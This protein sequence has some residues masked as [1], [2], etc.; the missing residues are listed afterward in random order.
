MGENI[1]QKSWKFIRDLNADSDEK[2]SAVAMTDGRRKYT[3]RQLFRQW[4]KYAEVF[5]ALDITRESCSVVGMLSTPSV[6][7]VVAFYSLNMTG[8]CVS[9][10]HPND[11]SNDGKLRQS[12]ILEGITDLVLCSSLL[13][14]QLLERLVITKALCN[15]RNIIILHTSL[16]GKYVSWNQQYLDNMNYAQLKYCKDVLFM[17]D[18]LIRYEATPIKYS[19]DPDDTALIVHTSGTTK[20]IHKPIPFTDRALNEAAGM[21]RG[22]ERFKCFM[23]RA[24]TCLGMD[25]STAYSAVDMMHVPLS[26]GAKV[27]AVPIGLLNPFA[28]VA[29]KD[30]GINVLFAAGRLIDIWMQNGLRPD[31][32][33]LEFI[34]LGGSYLSA[35]S[36]KRYDNYL[37]KCGSRVKTSNGYGLSE[38]G[39]A[40]IVASPDREDDAIGFPLSGVKVK[41][42]NEDDGKYYDLGEGAGRGVMFLSSS[43]LS[44]GRIGDDIIFSFENIDGEKYLNTYDL[45]I[46]NEDG[47]LS[48]IGRMDKYFVNNDGIRF[49]AGIVETAIS[50]E[51]GIKACAL[52]PEYDDG[53]HDTIPVLYVS[54]DDYAI[55]QGQALQQVIYALKNVFIFNGKIA[56]SNLPGQCVITDDIP[57]TMTGKVDVYQIKKG[58]VKG[59]RYKVTPFFDQTGLKDIRLDPARDDI[60][61]GWSGVPMELFF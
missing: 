1:S 21:I 31:F 61:G 51:A 59:Y 37:K 8:A 9:V 41:L 60:A 47:S 14:P 27:V 45:V 34:S 58:N 28:V 2:L 4:E 40:C 57:H 49:D 3:Y 12:I 26:F 55:G 36:K 43:S 19:D 23:G 50:A 39:G 54:V 33:R 5:S 22:D 53:L 24:V 7:S 38:I 15:L 16:E 44:S 52:A 17:D 10:F 46:E 20:G 48:C 18:L 6:E 35:E 56:E 30:Y 25:L 13:T 11:F 42:F 32:S 29:I